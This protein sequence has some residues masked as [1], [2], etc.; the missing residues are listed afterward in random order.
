MSFIIT[1]HVG[2]G[3][4]MASDSRVTFTTT[5]SP[6]NGKQI[7][8]LGTHISDTTYKTFLTPSNVGISTCGE[9]SFNGKT[10]TGFIENYI[11]LHKDDNVDEVRDS[12]ISYFKAL[13]PNLNTT[14]II[15][16]YLKDADGQFLPKC[17]KVNIAMNHIDDYSNNAAVWDGERS[18]MSRL[19]SELYIKQNDGTFTEHSNNDI[20]WQYFTLQ[21]AIDFAR[22]AVQVTIDTMKF[23]KTVK[24]VGGPVDVLIIQ[25][26]GGRWINRKELK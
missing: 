7:V 14:F 6:E 1:I 2:E 9:S 11:S 16:G 5:E 3:F 18:V 21:D 26:S 13:N 20:L 17:Y 15:A 10:L 25:P 22:Y 19:T 12:I 4:V 24:T 23:Q 8:K